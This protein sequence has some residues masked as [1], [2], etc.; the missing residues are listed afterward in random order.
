MGKKNSFLFGQIMIILIGDCY[1]K[2]D[3][4]FTKKSI[5][6]II[7]L[8]EFG[9]PIQH[10]KNRRNYKIRFNLDR[11]TNLLKEEEIKKYFICTTYA[12][13]S[14]LKPIQIILIYTCCV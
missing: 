8:F 7:L 10:V 5:N 6:P 12:K 3:W 4:I 11:T 1:F 13:I 9:D 2:L 14:N